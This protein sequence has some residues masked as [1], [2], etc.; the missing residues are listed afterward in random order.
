MSGDASFLM[1]N[2]ELAVAAQEGIKIILVL[3]DNHGFSSVGNVSEQV[4]WVRASD[5]TTSTAVKTDDTAG[6]SST[7]TSPRSARASVRT[8]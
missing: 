5:V 4:G 1:M 8:P 7:T 3:I 2:S 6:E